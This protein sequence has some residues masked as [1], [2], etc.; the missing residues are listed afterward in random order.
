MNQIKY[1]EGEILLNKGFTARNVDF[2][3]VSKFLCGQNWK[4]AKD[5]FSKKFLENVAYNSTGSM[6]AILWLQLN[7]IQS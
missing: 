3:T 7:H 1:L 6:H 2:K 4:L 5:P